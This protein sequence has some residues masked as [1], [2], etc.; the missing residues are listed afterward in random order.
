MTVS[1]TVR[2]AGPYA[3]N[4]VATIF[5][6][7]F[8]AFQNSD[9]EV[10]YLAAGAA[11]EEILVLDSDYSVHLNADQN[12]TP[13]KVVEVSKRSAGCGALHHPGG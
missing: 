12:A 4:G 7:P 1:S 10:I 11:S 8:K 9:L 6:F 13:C 5:S 2:K 3:G